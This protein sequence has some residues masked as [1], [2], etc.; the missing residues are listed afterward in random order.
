MPGK[1]RCV[2]LL[3][4]ILQI[5]F[6]IPD[7]L[8]K[9]VAYVHGLPRCLPHVP[10]IEPQSAQHWPQLQHEIKRCCNLQSVRSDPNFATGCSVSRV[11]VAI[12]SYGDYQPG[13]N[14]TL[15]IHGLLKFKIDIK[16]CIFYM[17]SVCWDI[18][19]YARSQLVECSVVC[20]VPTYCI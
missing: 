10:S 14:V 1:S 16:H 12:P 4:S 17:M 2:I 9:L 13:D 7:D 6:S 18:T 8:K 19:L 11:N 15:A 5:Q 20:R 3:L